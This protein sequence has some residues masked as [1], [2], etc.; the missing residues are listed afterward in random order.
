V[1]TTSRDGAKPSRLTPVE[2]TLSPD[3]GKPESAVK[4]TAML[5]VQCAP[6]QTGTLSLTWD[7]RSLSPTNIA[8]ADPASGSIAFDFMVPA[9]A[10][11][12]PHT[13]AAVCPPPDDLR[14]KTYVAYGYTGSTTFTVDPTEKPTLTLTPSEGAAGSRIAASGT[15]FTCDTNLALLWDDGSVL[16]DQ[17]SGTFTEHISIPADAS[18]GRGHTVTAS[19]RDHPDIEVSQPF[20]VTPAAASAT[21]TTGESQ[22]VTGPIVTPQPTLSEPMTPPTTRGGPP[23]WL[24]VLIVAAVLAGATS[25]YRRSRARPA[26]V[27]A[28]VRAVPRFDP[29]PTV[30][31]HETPDPG[32]VTRSIGLVPHPDPGTQTFVEVSS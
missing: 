18:S 26:H 7:G 12:G 23:W 32:D 2:I 14:S 17:L 21:V 22:A 11:A 10:E 6:P 9:T 8:A 28:D 30:T 29:A 16:A 3:H 13:V 31:V 15:G 19:C 25:F 24:I 27:G 20:T 4:V 1:T 5:M